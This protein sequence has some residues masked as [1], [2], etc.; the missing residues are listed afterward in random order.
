[1]KKSYIKWLNF[2]FLPPENVRRKCCKLNIWISFS[3]GLV[4]LGLMV[5]SDG[6]CS[7]ILHTKRK[8]GGLDGLNVEQIEKKPIN[9][10]ISNYS[11][12]EDEEVQRREKRL[13]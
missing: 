8:N 13:Y 12:R 9:T 10:Y 3:D 5:R 11:G 7:S 2:F 4:W 6:I 1:M